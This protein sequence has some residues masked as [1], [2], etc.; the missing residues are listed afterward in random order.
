MVFIE[1]GWMFALEILTGILIL[2]SCILL[3]SMKLFNFNDDNNQIETL[4]ESDD[5]SN[6][7]RQRKIRIIDNKHLQYVLYG[8]IEEEDDDDDD[9]EEEE[10]EEEEQDDDDDDIQDP[11][12]LESY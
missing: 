6:I 9:D 11:L 10:Q 5:H 1:K 2:F 8:K 4:S 7:K 3:L 12:E